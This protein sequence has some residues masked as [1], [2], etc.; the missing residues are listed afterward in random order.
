MMA[1]RYY[2][3]RCG[4]MCRQGLR[5]RYGARQCP[6][7]AA[8]LMRVAWSRA[9]LLAI[10]C[11]VVLAFA[12]AVALCAA[13]FLTG[14]GSPFV[15]A[16]DASPLESSAGAGGYTQTMAQ[17]GAG[18]EAGRYVGGGGTAST[19]GGAGA[20]AVAIAGATADSAHPCDR[21]AWIA[22]AFGWNYVTDA[23]GVEI[24]GG[25]PS[26]AVDNDP[27]SSWTSG[28]SQSAGQWFEID[29]GA[30]S[31]LS[32]LDVTGPNLPAL[33]LE[34]D[35]QPTVSSSSSNSSSSSV[36]LR[37][38]SRRARVVRVSLLGAAASWWQINDVQAVCL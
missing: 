33:E 3:P 36:S 28:E 6:V 13:A 15:A 5:T 10:D 22:T 9:W 35:G 27:R 24:G 1:D 38:E 18:A 23:G 17:A 21:S 26:A 34:L 29:L 12:V 37:F 14:C 19:N 32:E 25:P 4:L 2:C 20:G 16:A 11:A 8:F 30:P 7:C 31:T